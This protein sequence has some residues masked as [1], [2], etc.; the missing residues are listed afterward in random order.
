MRDDRTWLD[1][2]NDW[3]LRTGARA[4]A[5]RAAHAADPQRRMTRGEVCVLLGYLAALLASRA[6]LPCVA[7]PWAR[8]LLALLPLPP[9]V[10][11]VALAVRRV[12]GM[13]ELQR[14]IELVVLAVTAAAAWLGF[15]VAWLLAE[16]GVA[17]PSPLLGFWGMPLLYVFARRWAG[18]RY[19]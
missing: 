15:S 18:R 14:R 2:L 4:F 1:G 16:A 11:L 12:S 17:L 3:L 13:D 6:G 9:I 8:A 5:G 7:A 19:A 10:L